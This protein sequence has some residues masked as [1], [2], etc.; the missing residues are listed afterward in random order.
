MSAGKLLHFGAFILPIPK[1]TGRNK[2]CPCGSGLKFKLCLHE[3]VWDHVLKE[4]TEADWK[5]ID[6]TQV[7]ST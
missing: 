2:E 7:E 5:K 4:I 6:E 3:A 1:D